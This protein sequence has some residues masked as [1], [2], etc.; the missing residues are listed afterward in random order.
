MPWLE[1]KNLMV[2]PDKPDGDLKMVKK[3]DK[4][5]LLVAV[6]FTSYSEKALVFASELAEKIEA[7]LLV[8]HV[9]HDPAEAPGFYSK[10]R[11]KEKIPA[12]HGGCRRRNDG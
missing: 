11:Q 10:K 6:D 2:H 5:T 1:Y 3:T 8:L 12:I 7:Q 4:K 9:I